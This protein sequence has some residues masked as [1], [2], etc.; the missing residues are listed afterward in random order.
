MIKIEKNENF[1]GF[2]NIFAFGQ[3][4][5]QVQ[6]R[7]KALHIAKE[8]AEENHQAHIINH[9]NQVISVKWKYQSQILP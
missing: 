2:F 1:G 8:I 3:F 7:A 4:V 9:K 6:G 5:D